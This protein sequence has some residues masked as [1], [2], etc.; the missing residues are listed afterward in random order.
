MR[1]PQQLAFYNVSEGTGARSQQRRSRA[2]RAFNRI[3]LSTRKV[4]RLAFVRRDGLRG[5]MPDAQLGSAQRICF[6]IQ[7]ASSSGVTAATDIPASTTIS[8]T[9]F[10]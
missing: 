6:R 7:R 5:R 2:S 3:A 4:D 8:A 10:E 1:R 9:D